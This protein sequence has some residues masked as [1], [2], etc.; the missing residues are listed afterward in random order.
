MNKTYAAGLAAFT[1]PK[2]R[3]SSVFL[4]KIVCTF[5]FVL[6]Y[7]LSY[8]QCNDPDNTPPIA[9]CSNLTVQLDAVGSASI[10][11]NDINSE[12][13]DNCGIVSYDIDITSFDCTDVG[14]PVIVKL[15][16]EDEAGNSNS[17]TGTVKIE[18]NVVPSAL[19]QNVTI[20]L[21][22]AGNGP[23]SAMQV[24]NGSNDACSLSGLSLSET[25]FTCADI[26]ANPVTLTAT[27]V[28]GNVAGCNAAVTV[29]DNFPPTASCQ[30]LTVQLNDMGS[31]SITADEIDDGSNDAC[32]SVGLRATPTDFDCSNLGVNTS[33]LTVTDVNNNSSTCTANVTVEDTAP[34]LFCP[35]DFDIF[36]DVNGNAT[37][38]VANLS[39]PAEMRRDTFFFTGGL[40]SFTVPAGVTEVTIEAAGGDGGS[41]FPIFGGGALISGGNGALL[42]ADF[43]VNA[44][45]VLQIVVGGLPPNNGGGGGTFIARG[46]NGFLSFLPAN[47]LLIA[48]GGGGATDEPVFPGG[49]STVLQNGADGG[50]GGG[51]FARGGGGGATLLNNGGSGSFVNGGTAIIMGGSGVGGFGGGGA[52][53]FG[54]GGGGGASGGQAGIGF[55]ADGNRASTGGTSFSAG[56]N[57]S[58]ITPN[59]SDDG[60]GFVVISYILPA[61]LEGDVTLSQSTFTCTDLGDKSIMATRV[62]ENCTSLCD[63]MVTVR[64]T[65]PPTAICQNI[66]VFL[67]DTGSAVIDSNAVD[68]NSSDNCDIDRFVLNLTSFT[69]SDLVNSPFTVS[70]TVYDASGLSSTCTAAVTVGSDTDGDDICDP[71][72]T[73]DDND[74]VNDDND[75][76]PLNPNLCGDAD[77]DGCDDCSVGTD[78]FGP[79]ADNNPDNDG[80][81][82]DA[83]GICDLGDSCINLPGQIGDACDDGNEFTVGD[84]INE[85]CECIGPIS[86]PTLSQWSILFLCLTMMIFGVVVVKF[87]LPGHLKEFFYK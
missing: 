69:C 58:A 34:P 23:I 24:D 50:G 82:T 84:V 1:E 86:I 43:V 74:G 16:V 22:A 8:G 26:G 78:G 76:F 2:T 75:P 68:N 63:F 61:I 33:T 4:S 45:E 53:F 87:S 7:V 35:D 48:G 27:D 39:R 3:G 9:M 66:T 13:T 73:D 29:Q 11:S 52:G 49:S 42:S 57:T 37:I 10:S 21:N 77:G 83:D 32:G 72:D 46:N 80:T 6:S 14:P 56:T 25:N 67:D 20:Q 5:I 15:T 51:G 30:N 44:N 81:D 64:D 54:G 12:S 60:N 47:A 71:E 17:C 38:D 55:A 79:L 19:C 18:D 62:G 41:F 31:A 65:I 59:P 40:Q 85:N 70:Q 36:L 28:N